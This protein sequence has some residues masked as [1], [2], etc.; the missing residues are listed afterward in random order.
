MDRREEARRPHESIEHALD[1]GKD[2]LGVEGVGVGCRQ[3]DAPPGR[4]PQ[5]IPLPVP[6]PDSVPLGGQ[7]RQGVE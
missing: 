5:P 2:Y 1:A 4:S 3:L 6:V 7:E